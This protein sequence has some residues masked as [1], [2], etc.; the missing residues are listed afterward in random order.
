[1]SDITTISI[2]VV[3]ADKLKNKMKGTGFSSLSSYATY[4]L[5]QVIS[6]SS[7]K[8]K[9]AFSA[10]EEEKVKERLKSLGYLD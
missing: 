3:L 1:M 5:R 2:P 4:I 6:E 8:K 7:S 9:E 10:E